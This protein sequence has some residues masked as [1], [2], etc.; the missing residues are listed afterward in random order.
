MKKE[1][2]KGLSEEQIAKVRECKSTEELLALANEEEVDLTK[3][4]LDAISG[5][6]CSTDENKKKDTNHQRI[7]R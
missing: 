6:V 3:E 4:Q 7:D 5:G 1:L 2:L